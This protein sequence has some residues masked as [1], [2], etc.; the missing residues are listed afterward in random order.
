MSSAPAA[1]DSEKLR[2]VGDEVLAGRSSDRIP[3]E[4]ASLPLSRRTTLRAALYELA[5]D[6]EAE[7]VSIEEEMVPPAP[8]KYTVQE[9]RDVLSLLR[10]AVA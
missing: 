1:T 9:S 4:I 8:C 2:I 6:V 10:V 7:P 3:L 5:A